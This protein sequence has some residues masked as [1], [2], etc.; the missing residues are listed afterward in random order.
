[1]MGDFNARHPACCKRSDEKRKDAQLIKTVEEFPDHIIHATR[2]PTFQAARNR[3][4]GLF[5]SSN[6]DLSVAQ[7]PINGMPRIDGRI[8]EQ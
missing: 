5:G 6:I 7:A 1:M 2:Q 3:G 4:I 8:A